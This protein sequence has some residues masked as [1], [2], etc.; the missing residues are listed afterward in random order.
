[1][2]MLAASIAF[3]VDPP[4]LTAP[5][6]VPIELT[7]TSQVEGE[8][9]G[10]EK[11]S[12]EALSTQRG[13]FTWHDIKIQLGAEVRTYLGSELVLQTNISWAEE[14]AQT[15]QFVSGALTPVDVAQLQA[16]VLSSGSISL[17]VGKNNVFL[18]N[19]GQTAIIHGTDGAIQNIILNTASNVEAVS[20]ID[21][22]LD[23]AD[24]GQ[25]QQSVMDMRLGQAIGDLVSHAI[26]TGN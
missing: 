5:Q 14:G 3:G 10:L 26:M 20:Q 1:M 8:L 19:N 12:N 6:P 2:W 25:F 22:V 4:P 23:L 13:G 17:N 18:A 7:E 16:G 24:F 21:V 9:A 11:V 15:T